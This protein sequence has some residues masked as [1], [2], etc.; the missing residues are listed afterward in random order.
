MRVVGASNS[1]VRGPYM[2]D[3]MIC[4]TIAAVASIIIAAP[5]VYFVS[6]YLDVFIPGLG[7][8]KYFYTHII[9]LFLYELCLGIFIGA[10]SSFIAVR[11]YLK[12]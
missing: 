8:F 9:Q 12:N 6:P 4:A 5:I 1:L 2:V 7:L 3:G 10:F 11:K